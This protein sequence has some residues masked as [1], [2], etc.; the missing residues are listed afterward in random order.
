MYFFIQNINFV[1][2][3]FQIDQFF[4]GMSKIRDSGIEDV[5][6]I[7]FSNDVRIW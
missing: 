2:N 5:V 1:Q 6:D 3:I 4:K 7:T